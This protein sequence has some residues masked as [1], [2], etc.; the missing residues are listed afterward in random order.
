MKHEGDVLSLNYNRDGKYLVT[1][2]SDHTARVWDASSGNEITRVQREG[3]VN[4]V[5][6]S[7]DGKYLATASDDKT[8]RAQHW[9]PEGLIDEACARLTRNLTEEEWRQNLGDEPYHKTCENLPEE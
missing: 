5:T 8:A 1:A 9:Q 3:A 4:D 6:F 7:P 2:S